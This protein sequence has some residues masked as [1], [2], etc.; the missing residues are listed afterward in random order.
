M[1]HRYLF[2]FNDNSEI[3]VILNIDTNNIKQYCDCMFIRFNY[4]TVQNSFRS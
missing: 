4:S 3:F 1:E 2:H